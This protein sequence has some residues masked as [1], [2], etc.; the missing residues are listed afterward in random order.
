MPANVES[1]LPLGSPERLRRWSAE[2]DLITLQRESED[3]QK[4][5]EGL[6]SAVTAGAGTTPE[7]EEDIR[8]AVDDLIKTVA[9]TVVQDGLQAPEN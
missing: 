4:A 1:S 5:K 8:L 7:Q 2:I 9:S 6:V 3:L